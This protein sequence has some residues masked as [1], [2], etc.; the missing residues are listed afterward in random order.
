MC[1]NC[2]YPDRDGIH[3]KMASEAIAAGAI[4]VIALTLAYALVWS[5]I[6]HFP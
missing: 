6:K 1:H 4:I 2:R 5:F 3:R